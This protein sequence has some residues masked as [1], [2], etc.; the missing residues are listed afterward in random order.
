MSSD[1]LQNLS[2][3]FPQVSLALIRCLLEKNDSHAGRAARYLRDQGYNERAK[4]A[5]QAQQAA[6]MEAQ[7][8]QQ[9]TVETHL[10]PVPSD[11]SSQNP[12]D[13]TV[14]QF[15]G[16]TIPV[17]VTVADDVIAVKRRIH[18][19]R[20]I[21][22]TAQTLLLDGTKLRDDQLVSQCV[23]KTP[24][25]LV[26][27][28]ERPVKPGKY[29]GAMS[30]EDSGE[31]LDLVVMQ[32][33]TFTFQSTGTGCMQGEDHFVRGTLK[34]TSFE[35]QGKLPW[36]VKGIEV[37]EDGSLVYKMRPNFLGEEREYKLSPTST[38]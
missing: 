22:P 26:L 9:A 14:H 3:R 10:A 7:Q 19:L 5:Q 29:R 18:R 6:I 34:G 11:A 31:W 38:A 32:D 30:F 27:V 33:G 35:Y 16:E 8:A 17:E 23:S 4:E 28:V 1:T 12:M 37:S 36:N 20:G 21:H 13:V 24:A 25:S 15:S 2:A